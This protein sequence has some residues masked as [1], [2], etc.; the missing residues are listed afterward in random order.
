LCLWFQLVGLRQNF[1]LPGITHLHPGRY[2][3][4]WACRL[5]DYGFTREDAKVLALGS[6]GYNPTD[7]LL[8]VEAVITLDLHLIHNYAN[9][10]AAIASRLAE[11]TAD[12]SAP[13]RD[14]ELPVILTPQ[15]ALA[16]L[17]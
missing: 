4:R 17:A 6:F 15:A 2:F 16:R 11:M 8:G 1:F 3:K 13:F 12:L 7:E 9:Q 10:K 14:A 5:R